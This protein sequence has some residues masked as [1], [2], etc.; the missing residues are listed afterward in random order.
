[1]PSQKEDVSFLETY[2]SELEKEDRAIGNLVSSDFITSEKILSDVPTKAEQE[3]QLGNKAEWLAKYA[4]KTKSPI[5]ANRLV[6]YAEA[7]SSP[8]V[9]SKRAAKIVARKKRVA[10]RRIKKLSKPDAK[11][12][13]AAQLAND[14]GFDGGIFFKSFNDPT[15]SKSKGNHAKQ[16]ET[17]PQIIATIQKSKYNSIIPDGAELLTISQVAR[18]LGWAE[19]VVRQRDKKGLLPTP[20][21]F[22]GTIQWNRRELQ[23]WLVTGCLPRDKWQAFKKANSSRI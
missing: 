16:S 18:M 3:R 22:G 13:R 6:K 11:A 5:R 17:I 23:D 19:S 8:S 7:L 21:R 10:E 14:N 9:V 4:S 1:M 12:M 2:L 20:H 15:S